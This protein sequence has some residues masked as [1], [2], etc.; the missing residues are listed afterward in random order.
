MKSVKYEMIE[1]LCNA[2][3]A[4]S[5]EHYRKGLFSRDYYPGNSISSDYTLRL[6]HHLKK[7]QAHDYSNY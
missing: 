3:R 7:G 2:S 5:E 6:R 1:V 4:L